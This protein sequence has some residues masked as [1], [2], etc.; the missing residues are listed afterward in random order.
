M[1]NL[2]IPNPGVTKER[3]HDPPFFFSHLHDSATS[4]DIFDDHIK[5][6]SIEISSPEDQSG[7]MLLG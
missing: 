7:H 2:G 3:G 4:S 1:Y 5:G 6:R